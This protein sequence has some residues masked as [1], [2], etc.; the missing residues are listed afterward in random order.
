MCV[1]SS[2]GTTV[3]G[4]VTLVSDQGTYW[5][6]RGGESMAT[7]VPGRGPAGRGNAAVPVKCGRGTAWFHFDAGHDVSCLRA[8]D[9]P[10][11]KAYP[12][13]GNSTNGPR[14]NTGKNR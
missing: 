14:M 12:I 8:L 2:R 13:Q 3:A 9:G 10:P 6:T 11:G 1:C 7:C 4:S 5:T